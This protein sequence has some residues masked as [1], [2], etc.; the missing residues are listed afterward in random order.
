MGRNSSRVSRL[1][2]KAK[3]NSRLQEDVCGEVMIAVLK[4]KNQVQEDVCS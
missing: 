4:T 2:D 3:T 1:K